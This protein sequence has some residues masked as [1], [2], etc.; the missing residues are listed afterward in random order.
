MKKTYI[1]YNL[2]YNVEVEIGQTGASNKF[3]ML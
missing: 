2:H 1:K 3:D